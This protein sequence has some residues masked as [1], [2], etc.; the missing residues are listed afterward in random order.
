MQAAWAQSR[1]GLGTL[2]PCEREERRRVWCGS[3]CRLWRCS[4]SMPCRSSE[5]PLRAAAAERFDGN[6]EMV[7]TRRACSIRARRFEQPPDRLSRPVGADATVLGRSLAGFRK[8]WAAA[9]SVT[10][11]FTSNGPL[12]RSRLRPGKRF[13]RAKSIS[14]FLRR[15]WAISSNAEAMQLRARSRTISY[16]PRRRLRVSLFGQHCAFNG[17]A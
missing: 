5:L 4:H 13:R 9:A 15:F 12:E 2:Q 14:T 3:E 6:F 10:S 16:F 11:S 17:Q 7:F 1:P 8:C